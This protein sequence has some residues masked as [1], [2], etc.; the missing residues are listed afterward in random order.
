MERMAEDAGVTVRTSQGEAGESSSRQGGGRV[1][2]GLRSGEQKSKQRTM[3][4]TNSGKCGSW[5]RAS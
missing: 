2:G 1:G 3:E 4:V 5:E